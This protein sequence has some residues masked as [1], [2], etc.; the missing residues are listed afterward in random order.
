MNTKTITAALLVAAVIAV[1][2]F[3]N[4]QTGRKLESLVA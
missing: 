1:V 4:N 2:M 3:I